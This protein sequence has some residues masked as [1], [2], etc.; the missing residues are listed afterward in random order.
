MA[1]IKLTVTVDSISAAI[2]TFDQ[3]KVYRS[4]T[5]VGGVYSEITGPLTRLTLVAGTSVYYYDDV[6]GDAGYFYKVSFFDSGS[7]LESSLSDPIEGDVDPLY[8][9]I[10]QVRDEG[11]PAALSDAQILQRIRVYQ[12]VIERV[13]RQWFVPKQMTWEFN[14]NG[15]TLMQFPVPIISVSALYVNE[16]FVNAVDVADFAAYTGRGEDTRDDR[17][18]PRIRIL[19]G[20]QSIFSG[21]G[22]VRSGQ[23]VFEIGEKNCKV[24]GTFGYIEPSGCVPDPIQ[25]ALLKLV[26]SNVKNMYGA[27]APAGAIIEEETDRHRRKYSDP[28]M[29]T[30]MF[31]P[32]GSGDREVDTILSMYRAPFAMGAPRTTYRRFTGGRTI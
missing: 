32:S 6:A 13:T 16:D 8:V 7:L 15:T 27:S 17:K 31:S 24:V 2:A 26:T 21:T 10:Q 22:S 14:G 20:E 11:V 30:K 23:L 12:Q 1:V 3:I 29:A 25:W 28:S 19:S 18:N 5:T 4:T 9:T